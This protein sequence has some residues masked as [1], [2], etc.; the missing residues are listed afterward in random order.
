M[1]LILATLEALATGL[2]SFSTSSSFTSGH[3]AK[4]VPVYCSILCTSS[5]SYCTYSARDGWEWVSAQQCKHERGTNLAFRFCGDQS[6]I[7]DSGERGGTESDCDTVQGNG[8]RRRLGEGFSSSRIT[9]T[10]YILISLEH[11]LATHILYVYRKTKTI[12]CITRQKQIGTCRRRNK[13]KKTKIREFM[14]V[15]TIQALQLLLSFA[16]G[17]CGV[18]ASIV[19]KTFLSSFEN[20]ICHNSTTTT[21]IRRD[22]SSSVGK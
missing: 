4:A 21:R 20:V 11:S 18:V 15:I 22:R 6:T 10:R 13:Q 7:Q 5:I 17:M 1:R 3:S 8:E 2:S 16:V 19:S 9:C 14:T 12:S